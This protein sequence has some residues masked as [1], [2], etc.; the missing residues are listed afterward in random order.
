MEISE[1]GKNIARLRKENGKT[2]EELAKSVGVS[3]Q[4]V[5]KWENGGVPDVGLLPAIADCFGVTVDELFGRKT[6]AGVSA[7]AAI[8]DAVN[9]TPRDKKIDKA[10][11]LC[12][13]VERA[14]FGEKP[15]RDGRLPNGRAEICADVAPDGQMYSSVRDDSGYTEM[16]LGNRQ[17]YFLIVPEAPDKEKAFFDGV[18][19]HSLFAALADPDFFGALVMLSKRDAKK[20]FTPALLEKGLGIEPAKAE[21]TI[22]ALRSYGLLEATT[23][24]MDDEVKEVYT[25]RASPSF[26]A[27]LIF[28]R[29]MTDIPDS[30]YCYRGGRNRPYLA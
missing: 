2:Q 27:M 18:D 24:E 3:A 11:E 20:A 30:F 19:Y 10:F 29:E 26:Q 1:M 23:L 7:E 8:A 21:K 12:W 25:F 5:S 13:A 17:P 16:S 22:A 9:D 4:A 14:L 28:A 6:G 15:G